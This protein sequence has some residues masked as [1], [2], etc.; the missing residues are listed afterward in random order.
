MHGH[1]EDS[2]K[3]N[4]LLTGSSQVS[5]V[6]PGEGEQLVIKFYFFK[7]PKTG[8]AAFMCFNTVYANLP[9]ATSGRP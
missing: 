8:Y 5:E 3:V 2:T 6:G 7:L 9:G 4:L 1:H